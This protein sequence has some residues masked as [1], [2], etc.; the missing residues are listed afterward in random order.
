MP[1][2]FQNIPAE[3]SAVP[4]WVMWKFMQKKGSDQITKVPYN[5][6]TG[7]MAQ[8]NNSQTWSSFEKVKARYEKGGYDGI[9]FVLD[10]SLGIVGV[11][12]DHC[13]NPDTGDLGLVKMKN[14]ETIDPGMVI[15]RLKS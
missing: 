8:S 15:Q 4:N 2:N 5:A 11:D 13:R 12:M 14:D 9:G 1:I 10:P 3:L 7:G 6:R